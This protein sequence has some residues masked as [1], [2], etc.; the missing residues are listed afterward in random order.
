[1]K[2]SL[3]LLLLLLSH[4][5]ALP[6]DRLVMVAP[7][8]NLTGRQ[9]LS[10][11]SPEIG[12]SPGNPRKQFRIDRYTHAPREILEHAIQNVPGL[13]PVER[14]QI[15]KVLIEV[16]GAIHD[17]LINPEKAQ[18][19]A[20]QLGADAIVMGSLLDFQETVVDSNAYSKI[21][22]TTYSATIRVRLIDLSVDKSSKKVQ[23][24]VTS[25]FLAT[26]K[27]VVPETPYLKL[28][29]SDWY[30]SALKD[31]FDRL[32]SDPAFKAKLSANTASTNAL[33]LVK[34]EFAV[35]P[36]NAS[37]YFGSDAGWRYVGKSPLV[38]NL[39][40]GAPYKIRVEKTGFVPWETLIEG[41]DG[42]SIAHE[43]SP[44]TSPDKAQNPI[45]RI[46]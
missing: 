40:L 13:K 26:G 44:H 12:G 46:P 14:T 7:F 8:D 4:I 5:P 34:V 35:T 36:T 15:D 9:R 29:N 2:K 24:A 10:D 30:Y 27:C 38:K 19:V 3:T 42:L 20:L 43:L 21:R 32:V 1:M 17:G 22:T 18:T 33:G 31:A 25:S 23:A 28:S 45:V 39:Q 6:A 11:Y 37:I 16:S 41:E